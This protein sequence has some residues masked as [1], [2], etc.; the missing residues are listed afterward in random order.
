MLA[1]QYSSIVEWW[2]LLVLYK[3]NRIKGTNH[4]RTNKQDWML[5]APKKFTFSIFVYFILFKKLK[6]N[7]WLI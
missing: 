7:L 6:A 5:Q 2:L 4:N 3:Y 1:F